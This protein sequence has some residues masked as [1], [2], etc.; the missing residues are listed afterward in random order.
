[1]LLGEYFYG[2]KI[3]RYDTEFIYYLWEDLI[4]D[5]WEYSHSCSTEIIK[6]H[7]W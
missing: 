4:P 6:C 3:D 1:M 5:I 2:W 7:L